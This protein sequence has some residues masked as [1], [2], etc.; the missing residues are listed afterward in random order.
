MS[1]FR[2]VAGTWTVVR[3][4]EGAWYGHA[5]PTASSRDTVF[6]HFGTFAHPH[7]LSLTTALNRSQFS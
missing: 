3:T 5:S 7:S 4:V 6:N 1:V 2:K